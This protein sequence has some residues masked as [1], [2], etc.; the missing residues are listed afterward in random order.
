M[1]RKVAALL[2]A[3][4]LF[5]SLA[6][7]ED[8]P[9]SAT[10]LSLQSVLASALRDHPS[11]A[12]A[13]ASVQ[14]AHAGIGVASAWPN[15]RIEAGFGHAKPPGTGMAGSES[16]WSLTQPFPWPGRRHAEV[17]AERAALAAAES[18]AA[19]TAFEV[20]EE[21]SVLF[22]DAYQAQREAVVLDESATALEALASLLRHRVDVGEAR[23][24]DA[25]RGETEARRFRQDAEA[26]KSRAGFLYGQLRVVAGG[27]VPPSARLELSDADSADLPPFA[28][29]EARL[30]SDGPDLTEAAALAVEGNLRVRAER[31]AW[32]PDVEIS[33][34]R[35]DEIDKISTGGTIAVNLPLFWRNR[36]GVARAEARS[37]RINEEGRL[38]RLRRTQELVS[39]Y[40]LLGAAR[41]RRDAYDA[42]I[43]P[44]ARHSLEIAEFSVQHGEVTLLE[45]LDSRRSWVTAAQEA[46]SARVEVVRQ[47]L[48][49]ERLL[50][51][52]VP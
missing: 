41:K 44:G 16:S 52:K 34:Y 8:I 14:E 36:Y 35:N 10:S 23:P 46:E 27:D 37:A 38:E 43:L 28:D 42:E 51:G 17:E 4:V 7:A 6:P 2:A 45:G 18:R 21:V 33:G 9:P 49:I 50:G 22:L 39:A 32:W 13:Q 24:L 12:A 1:M 20:R 11:L 19:R 30:R 48:R 15:P 3:L 40:A 47:R 31:R 26:A 25:L 29:L 5:V